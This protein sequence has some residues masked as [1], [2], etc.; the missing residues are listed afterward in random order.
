MTRPELVERLYW[1]I[2]LRW[3][4]VAGVFLTVFLTGH[5]FEFSLADKPLDTTAI[6][7]GVYNLAL[8]VL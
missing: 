5:V 4:A 6:V 1:L 2:R 7:L 8:L 3:V